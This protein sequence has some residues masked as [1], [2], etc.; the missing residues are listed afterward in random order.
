MSIAGARGTLF[1]RRG[2]VLRV[3][4]TQDQITH[5]YL[6]YAKNILYKRV[7]RALWSDLIHNLPSW[8]LWCRLTWSSVFPTSGPLDRPIFYHASECC[9]STFLPHCSQSA[10]SSCLHISSR[11]T[12][13]SLDAYFELATSVQPSPSDPPT[14]VMSRALT[15][16]LQSR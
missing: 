12:R 10:D 3:I 11:L 9:Q 14:I 2:G 8:N 4:I 15:F 7:I 6:T 13:L 5:P 16:A 1:I